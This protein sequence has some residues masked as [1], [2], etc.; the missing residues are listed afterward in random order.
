LENSYY[1][2]YVIRGVNVLQESNE[3][4]TDAYQFAGTFNQGDMVVEDGFRL[5][6]DMTNAKFKSVNLDNFQYVDTGNLMLDDVAFKRFREVQFSVYNTSKEVVPFYSNFYVD[7]VNKLNPLSYTIVHITD[8]N[9]PDYGKIF[10]EENINYSGS[11]PENIEIPEDL[12]ITENTEIQGESNLD[13][14]ELDLAAFPD[15][16]T[17]TV[18][19]E[20]SGKGRRAGLVLLNTSLK[21]YELSNLAFVYRNMNAR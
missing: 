6:L 14:W 17:V 5:P 13:F 16:N 15:L 12:D 1:E 20:L 18:R 10:I 8:T 9:D 19:L 4:L 2:G 11:F 7:G 3:I 21:R